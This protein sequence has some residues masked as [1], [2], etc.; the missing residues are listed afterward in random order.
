MPHLLAERHERAAVLRPCGDAQPEVVAV[1]IRVLVAVEHGLPLQNLE[2]RRRSTGTV[3]PDVCV[4]PGLRRTRGN[5]T[6]ESDTPA[7]PGSL[8]LRGAPCVRLDR[9]GEPDGKSLTLVVVE[10]SEPRIG[11]VALRERAMH[12][13]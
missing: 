9:C 5:V 4:S 2:R 7:V 1:G 3:I 13:A 8:P 10:R 6:S 12:L 11:H